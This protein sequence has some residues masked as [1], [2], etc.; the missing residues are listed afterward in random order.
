[1]IGN[2]WGCVLGGQTL[3]LSGSLSPDARYRK[4]HS[5]YSL[6]ERMTVGGGGRPGSTYWLQRTSR[7]M[8]A[9]AGIW[10][11]LSPKRTL[12]ELLCFSGLKG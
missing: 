1:M 10:A 2:P 12:G 8:S 9:S 6:E 11:S 4:M 7:E 3:G 5:K